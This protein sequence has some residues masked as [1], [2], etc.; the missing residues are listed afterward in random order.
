MVLVVHL[1][2]RKK[3]GPNTAYFIIQMKPLIAC[4]ETY[5]AWA[6]HHI[7]YNRYK[8][9]IYTVLTS[10]GCYKI[11]I[12]KIEDNNFTAKQF[13]LLDQNLRLAICTFSAILFEVSERQPCTGKLL[14]T[15]F[16]FYLVWWTLSLKI[17]L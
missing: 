1:K 7:H 16:I 9:N 12:L 6:Y 10:K 3:V 8:F 11:S 17:N 2:K 15:L 4:H 13:N 5:I 14:H